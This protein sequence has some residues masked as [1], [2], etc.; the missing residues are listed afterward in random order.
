MAFLSNNNSL[1]SIVCSLIG[2][3]LFM[4]NELSISE[5]FLRET[6]AVYQKLVQ[7][8]L[9]PNQDG[10]GRSMV[11][12]PVKIPWLVGVREHIQGGSGER[13]KEIQG[14]PRRGG[15]FDW[16][17]MANCWMVDGE[18]RGRGA[19]RCER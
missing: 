17:N 2:I 13:A 9:A 15:G 6:R 11:H 5:R 18:R 12:G 1:D 19:D 14:P 4:Q 3:V 7:L 8:S 10:V 16:L